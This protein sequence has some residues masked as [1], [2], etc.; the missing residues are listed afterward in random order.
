MKPIETIQ[1]KGCTIKVHI[2]D[3]AGNPLTN[4]DGMP[5]VYC[6]S[7]H[8]HGSLSTYNNPPS[9]RELVL[10]LPSELFQR[11]KRVETLRDYC[12][13]QWSEIVSTLHDE[14]YEWTPDNLQNWLADYLSEQ[15]SFSGWG[16]T[17]ES[18]ELI[19]SLCSELGWACY[20]TQINGYSQGDCWNVLAIA[21]PDFLEATG[22]RP[23]DASEALAVSVDCFGSWLRGDCYGYTLEDSE[24]EEIDGSCW[25]FIGSNHKANGLLEYA[26]NDVDC[27][28][29]KQADLIETLDAAFSL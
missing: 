18:F 25:G 3:D 13:M 12:A 20:S 2:D 22:I 4:C 26:K 17:I 1:Y 11:G 8:R 10:A 21:T 19:E 24:G 28:L 7:G 29:A 15:F 9:L 5:P 27:H 6:Y 14:L 23:E 16:Y